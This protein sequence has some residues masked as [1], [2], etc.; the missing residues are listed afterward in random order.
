MA[1]TQTAAVAAGNAPRVQH[2]AWPVAWEY[3][4][5]R[6]DRIPSRQGG[7]YLINRDGNE[8]AGTTTLIRAKALI[9]HKIKTGG[10]SS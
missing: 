2:Q 8:S 5:Y 10:Y 3:R 6:I 1:Q 9:D 7:G 4:G